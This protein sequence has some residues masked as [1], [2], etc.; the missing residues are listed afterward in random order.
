MSTRSGEYV[1]LRELRDD[2]GNDA[3]RFFY[4]SRSNDQHLDFDLELAKT[5]SN[6]NPV[7]YIQ[8]AHA[9]IASML[10]RMKAEG[11]SVDTPGAGD[12]ARLAEEEERTLMVALSRYPEIVQLAAVNRAPQHLVHYLRETAAAFHAC[13]NSHRVLVDDLALRDARVALTLAT[14]QIVR[15][16]LSLLGVT[17]PD[18]M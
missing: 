1:T 7:Y 15:N 9:R 17:A 3:A 2:V 6:D 4:V 13:Y 11:M 16:G 12:L 5:Q 18:S 14:Q 8:Y 10:R